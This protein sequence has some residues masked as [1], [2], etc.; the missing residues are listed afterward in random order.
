M[1]DNQNSPSNSNAEDTAKTCGE[2]LSTSH[3]CELTRRGE[4]EVIEVS[5]TGF[6]AAIAL[7][8][9]Q[10]LE[11]TV[12]EQ[13]WIWLSE[14]A[15][16][17]SGQSVRGGI[18]VCWPWFGGAERNPADVQQLITADN[19]AA[20]GFARS[21]LWSLSELE[22]SS[23]LITLVFVL[24]APVTDQWS[25]AATLTLEVTLSAKALELKLTTLAHAPIHICQAL[26][27]Y[28]A[29]SDISCTYVSG[30]QNVSYY[31]ALDNWAKR[32]E[33]TALSFAAET[34][35][36]Y[37]TALPSV[38]LQTPEH[39]LNL[40]SN[41][42]SLVVWNP[43]IEKA[44]RLSQFDEQAYQRMF[45]VE[46]ANLLSDAVSLLSGE[47]HTLSMRLSQVN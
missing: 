47:S 16:Y 42:S 33:T 15:T 18:P 8:G 28:F 35:R 46:T 40:T 6:T 19:P 29:T 26:H 2:L 3:H 5:G 21:E 7:Q 45:C 31:D 13:P 24:S 41:S 12:G 14:E 23:D 4:L 20:H 38:T 43:W 34:D 25:G 22:E 30:L 17:E 27:S 39:A 36:V 1:S 11:F 44:K 9:A 37:D 32:T 10:L